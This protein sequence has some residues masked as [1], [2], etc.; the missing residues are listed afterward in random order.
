MRL[1]K[2][3]DQIN[4][5]PLLRFVS[6]IVILVL[7]SIA[8]LYGCRLTELV[9]TRFVIPAYFTA[10]APNPTNESATLTAVTAISVAALETELAATRTAF[11]P[12]ATEPSLQ[13]ASASYVI[14]ALIGNE[15][16]NGTL[17][18]YYNDSLGILETM[19]VELE[20]YFD[21]YYVTPTPFG[22]RTLVPAATS[23]AF[24]QALGTVTASPSA[25]PRSPRFVGEPEM[26]EIYELMGASLLCL[27]SS[28]NGCDG[29]NDDQISP[30]YFRRIPLNGMKWSWIITPQDQA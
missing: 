29:E 23:A 3:I 8:I 21:N 6:Q 26:L 10:I 28:F 9:S 30:A 22:T 27:E 24:S 12:T 1:R 19:R 20:L 11:L 13:I 25:T 5:R 7:G 16:G 18:I 17:L 4:A 15:I 2:L 14:K